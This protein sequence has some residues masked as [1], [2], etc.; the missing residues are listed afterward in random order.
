MRRGAAHVAAAVF[1]SRLAGLLRERIFA[2]YL[3]TS[4]AADAYGAAFRIPAVMESMLGE[5][6]VSSAFIPRYSRLLAEERTRDASRLAWTVGAV[7]TAIV[8]L[9]VTAGVVLAP[10]L[11]PLIAPGF[12]PAKT[13]LTIRLVRVVFPA[14]GVLAL[15]AWCLGV[16]NGRRRFFLPYS[17]PILSALSISAALWLGGRN[18]LDAGGLALAAATGALVGALLQLAVQLPVVAALSGRPRLEKPPDADLREVGR[19]AV[20]ATVRGLIARFAA[21]VEVA[22]AGFVST[23]ALAALNYAQLLYSLPMGLFSIAISAALLPELAA[24]SAHPGEVSRR[25]ETPLRASLRHTAFLLVPCAVAFVLLG[26]VIVAAVYQSGEFGRQDVLYVWAILGASAV[27]IVGTSMGGLYATAFYAIGDAASP[28]RAAVWRLLCR[29]VL[30]AVLAIPVVRL[31][32]L[33]PRWGAVGLGAAI[34]VSGWIEFAL[35]RRW[36]RR[37]LGW[38]RDRGLTP[39]LLRLWGVALLAAGLAWAVKQGVGGWGP[40]PTAVAVLGTYGG[41]Y[42]GVTTMARVP[43]AGTL[44][45]QLREWLGR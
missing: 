23:G 1:L 16:L 40:V 36:L 5:R 39:F 13:A 37:R 11:V 41:V 32:G 38:E 24:A 12:D 29:A 42:L 4:D 2:H 6:V 43:E 20:P 7:Q 34:G 18:G 10:V 26:D 35:L 45:T 33:E 22:I 21:W 17:V 27:G 25:L 31:L 15:G 30:G 8:L 9:L 3:G 28:L 14:V 19:N 44:W